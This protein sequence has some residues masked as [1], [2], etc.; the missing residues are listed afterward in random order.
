M[1]P[2]KVLLI[3]D[4]EDD[5]ILTK[6]IFNDIPQKENYKLSWINNYEEGI[7][8]MLKSHYD[9]YLVDYRL[10]KHTGIDLL[11]EAIKSNV[12]EPIIILTGKGDAKVDHEALEIG[13]ADYLIKDQINPYTIER[14][15]R[16]A[17]KH[18]QSLKAL[19]ES[20]NK[21][22][23]IF[24]RSKEPF[25]IINSEGIIRDINK[26]GLDFFSYSKEEL[27]SINSC[28]LYANEVDNSIFIQ[29]MDE[30]GSIYDF[31]TQL[32]TKNK[33]VRTV[34]ISAFLQ[35]DQ[36]AT[37]EL[38]YCIIHDLTNRKQI[39]QFSVDRE[40]FAITER[41]AKNLA[42]E[43]RN[44]LSSIN[45]SLEQLKLDLKSEDENVNL[46]LDIIKSNFEKINVVIAN[47]VNSTQNKE[48]N[49]Q[50]R[51]LNSLLEDNISKVDLDASIKQVTIYR[52]FPS[53]DIIVDIDEDQISDAIH[54]V[55]IHSVKCGCQNI[56]LT[57][58]QAN[59]YA[60]I[61]IKNDGPELS[62]E[63]Q[64]RIFEPFFN[65]K[66]SGIGLL[67]AQRIILSHNGKLDLESNINE[68]SVFKIA[69]PLSK[70]INIWD[71]RG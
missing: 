8:A 11:H 6:E 62:L 5:Y 34:N 55:L 24:E 38:Y 28:S 60:H 56:T 2:V 22:R 32:I 65:P 27:K 59:T 14:S 51:S 1:E 63:E 42:N 12:D 4:D 18:T 45:L 20:E 17:L 15:L 36:H 37:E 58:Y 3:D 40:K 29:R 50:S 44:P 53:N 46:Y 35:I 13:A 21:F 23:I 48:L 43:I 10:G 9:I 39:E 33:E 25:L 19:K 54:A 7:N 26:A 68:D 61:E 41:V 52:D 69:L 49:I 47:L 31:E 70:Q 66:N 57:T 64:K 67:N 16:Y 71:S 30:K